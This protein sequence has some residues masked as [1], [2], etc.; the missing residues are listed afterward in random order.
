MKL[1]KEDFIKLRVGDSV[2]FESDKPF[3]EGDELIFDGTE[4]AV[5]PVVGT[6]SVSGGKVSIILRAPSTFRESFS[7][8]DELNCIVGSGEWFAREP[9]S[10]YQAML[11]SDNLRIVKK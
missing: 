8:D 4:A 7:W 6:T 2:V 5:F 1:S 11:R 9:W 10:K 3:Y